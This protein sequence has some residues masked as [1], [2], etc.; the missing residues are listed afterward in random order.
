MGETIAEGQRGQS[1]GAE[2]RALDELRL[3]IVLAVRGSCDLVFEL[4]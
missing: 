4:V 2:S 1:G 3:P